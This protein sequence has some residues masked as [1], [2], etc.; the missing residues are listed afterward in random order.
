MKIYSIFQLALA[1]AGKARNNQGE[2]YLIKSD[3]TLFKNRTD[4]RRKRQTDEIKPANT[5]DLHRVSR[6]L[7]QS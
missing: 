3:L 4:R 5:E 6:R 7:A 2:F 1:F